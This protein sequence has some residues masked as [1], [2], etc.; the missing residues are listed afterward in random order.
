MRYLITSV[1][2]FIGITFSGAQDFRYGKVSKEELA[3]KG[4]PIDS[5]ANAAV[6]FRE[7]KINFNYTVYDGFVQEREVYERVKIYTKE[8]YEWATKKIFIYKGGSGKT[9]QLVNVKGTT[10]NLSNGKVDKDKLRNDGIFEEE[11]NEYTEISTLTMPNI[12]DGAVIEYSYKIISPFL[13]IDDIY[14]QSF[15]PTNKLE[16]FI[17][18]PQFYSY[19]KQVNLKALYYPKFKEGK[20]SRTYS[21]TNS[22]RSGTT[23]SQTTFNTSKSEY[24]DNTITVS[25]GNIPAIKGESFAGNIDN[26]ISKMSLELSAILNE[27]GAVDKSFSSS[28]EKV[29]E[30]IYAY[31]S[32]GGQFEKT[33]FFEADIA[34]LLTDV[35]DPLEKITILYSYVKSKVKWNSNKGYTSRKGIREAYKE[36]IGNVGDINLLLIAMLKSQGINANPVLVSTK[37]NG[38]P[39]FPTRKGFNYV[40]CSVENDE[41]IILLDATDMYSAPNILPLRVLNWQGRIIRENGTSDWVPL[42]PSILSSASTA[43]N[44]KL[45]EDLSAEGKVRKSI[46]SHSALRYR[47]RFV[48]M[49]TDDHIKEIEKD[50]GNIEVSELV[51]EN[52]KNIMKPVKVSYDYEL[53]DAM[54]AIGSKLYLTPLLFLADKESPFKLEKRDYPIDFILP[55]SDKYFINIILPDNYTVDFMPP[56]EII[57]FKNGEVSY[58]YIAKQNGQYLQFSITFELKNSLIDP[59]DYELFKGFYEKIIEKQAEQVVLIKT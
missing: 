57:N 22:S 8:G 34:A 37:D 35:S 12:Q 43:L 25:E 42:R 55:K 51:I 15:I 30:T 20:D 33:K 14:F 13:E 26:Y 19:D 31:K 41:G 24:F 44:V 5:S 9:E 32:F 58:S 53:T 47:N 49:T 28:W 27:Y 38:I 10:Y 16:I 17:A 4:H 45:T 21:S 18:T 29:S 54:E 50:K 3:Q 23:T 56:S 40:I 6:L 11:Y 1:V 7:E 52:I 39:I 2:F 59:L 36:G 48:S 46:N